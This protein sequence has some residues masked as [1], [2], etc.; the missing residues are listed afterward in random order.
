[1]DANEWCVTFAVTST[2][3]RHQSSRSNRIFVLWMAGAIPGFAI[4]IYVHEVANDVR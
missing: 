4:L 1:V 3:A 2:T